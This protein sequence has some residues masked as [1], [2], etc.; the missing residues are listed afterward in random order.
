MNLA[1]LKKEHC[2]MKKKIRQRLDEFRKKRNASKEVLFL[3][4]CYCLCTPLSKAERVYEVITKENKHILLGHAQGNV[5]SF[6]RGNCR[7]HRNKARYIVYAR[8][9]VKRMKL[10]KDPMEARDYL[11]KNVKGLGYKEA[12]HFL[13]NIGY[14]GLAILDVHILRMLQCLGAIRTT[15]RPTSRKKYLELEERMRAFAKKV[16]IDIDELDLLLWSMR[17][18]EVLK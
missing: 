18:G 3:E 1:E 12:S 5:A 8:E 15:E 6:L 2:R 7:F 16:R 14:R 13:R 4:L 17:T 9:F 10:P 11:V